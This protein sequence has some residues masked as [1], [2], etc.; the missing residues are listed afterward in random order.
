MTKHR[1]RVGKA[2]FIFDRQIN[3]PRGSLLHLTHFPAFPAAG[4]RAIFENF[5]IRAF[6]FEAPIHRVTGSAV[7]ATRALPC[8]LHITRFYYSNV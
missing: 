3:A 7:V 6:D 5:E 2:T 1:P 4:A 8:Q